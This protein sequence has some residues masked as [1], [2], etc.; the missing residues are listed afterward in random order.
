MFDLNHQK[1]SKGLKAITELHHRFVT[2]GSLSIADLSKI[3]IPASRPLHCDLFYKSIRPTTGSRITAFL[4]GQEVANI[5]YDGNKGT[6]TVRVDLTKRLKSG[7][8]E[9]RC[10]CL[11]SNFPLENQSDEGLMWIRRH[12]DTIIRKKYST[13]G[14]LEPFDQIWK[15][16]VLKD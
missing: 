5:V 1:G 14:V 15:L 11:V 4:N 16:F 2:E 10:R 13:M 8:N 12:D 6:K 7:V 9:L 3:V